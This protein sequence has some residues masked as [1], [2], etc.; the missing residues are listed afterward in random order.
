[1]N[2][3][4]VLRGQPIT[5]KNHSQII[6]TGNRRM[7]IPSPQYRQYEKDCMWQIPP[8]AKQ[9]IDFPVN[10]QCVYY[11]PTKRRVDLVNLLEATCDILVEGGVLAAGAVTGLLE[12]NDD[13]EALLRTVLS[14]F[15]VEILETSPIEYRCYC[16][17]D[18]VERALISLGEKELESILREQGG[19]ELT[20]QF[21]DTVHCFTADEL[22]GL[23]DGLKKR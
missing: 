20:C 14:D 1:M 18:R 16:S 19:C 22:Q 21:C 2:L 6:K 11:M 23:I 17:R 13:P 8:K 9:R 4:M 7:V 12:K 3:K 10:V 15:E 5:K